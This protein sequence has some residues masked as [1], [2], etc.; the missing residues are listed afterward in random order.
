MPT[1]WDTFVN[2][3]TEEPKVDYADTSEN[4]Y[5][6]LHFLFGTYLDRIPRNRALAFFDPYIHAGSIRIDTE[7]PHL[8]VR[9]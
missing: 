7:Y 8:I 9:A 1:G 5:R 6:V 3:E 2:E 4:R